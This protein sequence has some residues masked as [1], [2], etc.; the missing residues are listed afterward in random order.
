MSEPGQYTGFKDKGGKEIY[1]G[2]IV[3]YGFGNSQSTWIDVI[4]WARGGFVMINY[5]ENE[6]CSMPI[7]YIKNMK[8]IGNIIETPEL[9]K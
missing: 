9:I 3:E 4:G 8:I 5:D 1:E 6:S 2:D 7:V